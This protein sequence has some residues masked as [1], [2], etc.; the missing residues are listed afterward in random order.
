MRRAEAE[1]GSG[2]ANRY[3]KSAIICLAGLH[4]AGIFLRSARRSERNR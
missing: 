1:R 3:V 2:I 4:V